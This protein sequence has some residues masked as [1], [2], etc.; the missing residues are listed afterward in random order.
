RGERPLYILYDQ[1]YWTLCFGDTRHVTPPGLLPEL[2]RYTVLID[3]IS[4][5]FAATGLRVGWAV[6]PTD[7]IAPMTPFLAHTR[8]GAPRPE[9]AATA[10][11]L[12]EAARDDFRT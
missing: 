4:K 7:L 3:G 6:G 11:Y 2:A 10:A 12:E 5:A 8:P 9:Q 1:V